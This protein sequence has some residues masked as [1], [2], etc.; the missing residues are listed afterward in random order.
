MELGVEWV[1][2]CLVAQVY[3]LVLLDIVSLEDVSVKRCDTEKQQLAAGIG[4][5]AVEAYPAGPPS[6]IGLHIVV[7]PTVLH[8]VAPLVAELLIV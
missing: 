2:N 7:I 3:K 5:G 1:R 4:Q 8:A 6:R